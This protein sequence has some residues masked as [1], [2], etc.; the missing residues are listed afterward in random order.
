MKEFTKENWKDEYWDD[1]FC[2]YSCILKE[3]EEVHQEWKIPYNVDVDSGDYE[4]T[5]TTVKKFK[6]VD[7]YNKNILV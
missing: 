7:D 6:S 2:S 5:T 3:N 4:G 1:D